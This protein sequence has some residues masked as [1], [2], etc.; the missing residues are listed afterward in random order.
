MVHSD[1]LD[2]PDGAFRLS[3]AERRRIRG[4]DPRLVEEILRRLKP[5][6][7][8]RTLAYF[9]GSAWKGLAGGYL[10]GFGDP[11]LDA[12]LEAAAAPAWRDLS[13]EDLRHAIERGAQPGMRTALQRRIEPR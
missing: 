3:D 5:K 8:A 2:A 13:V 1:K 6:T 10:L 12:L 4:F 11:E 9:D 7:R